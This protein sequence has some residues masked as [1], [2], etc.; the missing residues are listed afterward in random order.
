RIS[1]FAQAAFEKG[2]LRSGEVV[3]DQPIDLSSP[4]MHFSAPKETPVRFYAPADQRKMSA[5]Q[6]AVLVIA[7]V[8]ITILAVL[9]T[10]KSS[11]P[12]AR[13]SF[14]QPFTTAGRVSER[15]M[16]HPSN[17]KTPIFKGFSLAGSFRRPLRYPVELR[18][19]ESRCHVRVQCYRA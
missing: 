11:L 18:A 19:L 1:Q 14:L 2:G 9:I 8:G 5:L 4:K 3:L 7:C 12:Y 10:R 15:Q 13:A 6:L 16:G 17:A